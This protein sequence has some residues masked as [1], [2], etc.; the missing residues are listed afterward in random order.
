MSW[1]VDCSAL[2]S[3]GVALVSP[4]LG[5]GFGALVN[6]DSGTTSSDEDILS[7]TTVGDFAEPAVS[8]G[9]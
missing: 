1:P 7:S 9:R 3:A 5:R 8:S 6:Q 4:I 2:L